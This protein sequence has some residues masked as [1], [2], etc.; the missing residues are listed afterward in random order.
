MKRATSPSSA[1]HG[2]P[3]AKLDERASVL[4][5]EA[6]AVTGPA[7]TLRRRLRF[8]LVADPWKDHDVRTALASDLA[9]RALNPS[10][11]G[12]E[13]EYRRHSGFLL[14]CANCPRACSRN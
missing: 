1:G 12:R 8:A 3:S 9:V 10:N 7:A 4:E 2:A 14:D 11:S 6:I 13:F 5:L